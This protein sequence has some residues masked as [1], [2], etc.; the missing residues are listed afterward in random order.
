M[1]SSDGSKSRGLLSGVF[2]NLFRSSLQFAAV[3]YFVLAAPVSFSL[4]PGE[5]TASIPSFRSPRIILHLFKLAS[6]ELY[7]RFPSSTATGLKRFPLTGTT[8]PP[9]RQTRRLNKLL[10]E[11]TTSS[12]QINSRRVVGL[13]AQFSRTLTLLSVSPR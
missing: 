3:L 10:D 9:S 1:I 4:A 12:K 7:I 13:R 2:L 6:C 11:E 8:R 5:N